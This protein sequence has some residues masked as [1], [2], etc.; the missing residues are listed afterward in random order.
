MRDSQAMP[1]AAL[2]WSL[3]LA[4]LLCGSCAWLADRGRDLADVVSL[5]VGAGLGLSIDVKATDFLHPGVGYAQ[6][7]KAGFSGRRSY[8]LRDRELGLP[9]S[10]LLW[11]GALRDLELWRLGGLHASAIDTWQDHGAWRRADL[12]LGLFA[13]LFGLRIGI[14][15]GELVDLLAGLVGL[16]PAGDDEGPPLAAEPEEAGVW[17][18]GDL[19]E[20]CDPP[21]GG[22]APTTPE[23]TRQLARVAGLDF[24]GITPH[25]WLEGTAPAE[26]PELVELG[27]RVRALDDEPGPIVLPGFEV[28]LGGAARPEGHVLLLVPDPAL[29][30]DWSLPGGDEEQWVA[31]RLASL[32]RE[33]RLWVPAHP[34]DHEPVR[35]PFFPDWAGTWGLAEERPEGELALGARRYQ[36][37]GTP[38]R[39]RLR[40]GRGQHRVVRLRLDPAVRALLPAL[41]TDQR[42]NLRGGYQDGSWRGPEQLSALA[43]GCVIEALLAPALAGE[44][45]QLQIAL[46]EAIQHE[47]THEPAGPWEL[48]LGIDVGKNGWQWTRLGC[49]REAIDTVRQGFGV[50]PLGSDGLALPAPHEVPIDGLETV[51]G[52]L[53]LAGLGVGR[54]G[55][56]LEP[57]RVFAL[58][59]RRMRAERRRLVPLAGSDNHRELIFPNLWVFAAERSRAALFRALREGRV[60]VGGPETCSFRARSD[61]EPAWQAVGAALAA[62][63]TVELRWQGQAELFADGVSLGAHVGG[64]RHT[65]EAGTW[66]LY[67]IVRGP[68]RSGWIH[69][70]PPPETP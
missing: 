5:E 35:I 29:A 32:P 66:H 69:V 2:R 57:A 22:H 25:L 36:V 51:S 11:V 10:A 58:L 28:M 67:R 3:L 9:F 64:Y 42:V 16:D 21:D 7:R 41:P 65:I 17:L 20:H 37:L 61:R 6:A 27:R 70:N 15:P 52:L 13:G 43:R 56:E 31:A 8:W 48:E 1:R 55:D 60:C 26:R 50:A 24:V 14:S 40:R 53:H 19:H 34:L 33:Q 54:R 49:T 45:A 4:P 63:R 38:W 44:L 62:D 18:V 68:S 23:E 46:R 59:E 30:F 12:E 39:E 47:L